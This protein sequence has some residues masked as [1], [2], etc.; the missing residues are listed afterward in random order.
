MCSETA[1]ARILV[2]TVEQKVVLTRP[3]SERNRSRPCE[4]SEKIKY[5]QSCCKQDVVTFVNEIIGRALEE[6][7]RSYRL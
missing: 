7:W 3:S 5:A 6:G 2:L 4:T 1:S